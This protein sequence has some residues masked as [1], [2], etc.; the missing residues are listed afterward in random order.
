MDNKVT[1][2]DDIKQFCYDMSDT[3]DK[4]VGELCANRTDTDETGEARAE[5]Y[6]LCRKLSDALKELGNGIY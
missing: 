2:I 5:V 1:T 3:L 4:K 6:T